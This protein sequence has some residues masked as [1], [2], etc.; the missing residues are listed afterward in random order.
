MFIT[1]NSFLSGKRNTVTVAWQSPFGLP[2]PAMKVMEI[3]LNLSLF[4]LSLSLEWLC[5]R[6]RRE[7]QLPVQVPVPVPVRVPGPV[8]SD[9]PSGS[10]CANALPQTVCQ[11]CREVEVY[12]TEKGN[13]Q[14]LSLRERL[15]SRKGGDHAMRGARERLLEMQAMPSRHEFA[16]PHV[17]HASRRDHILN[18]DDIFSPVC[19]RHMEAYSTA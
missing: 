15:F 16:S 7:A 10:T 13:G 1:P 3:S 2:P 17:T 4:Q 18:S 19:K 8:S 6:K 14:S 12:I 9:R 11:R 5:C